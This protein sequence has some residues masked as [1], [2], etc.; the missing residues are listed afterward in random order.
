MRMALAHL[1]QNP[2]LVATV[3]NMDE[4][5]DVANDEIHGVEIFIELVDF[6]AQRPNITTAQLVELWHDHPALA[7]LQKLAVWDLPGEEEIQLQEFSDAVNRIRLSWVEILLSRVTNIIEQRVEYRALQQRR[8]D[9]KK[10]LDGNQ[11]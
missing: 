8:Q 7:H 2:A 5:T 3:G 9:L 1:V 6:C 4:F 10:Q 11:P